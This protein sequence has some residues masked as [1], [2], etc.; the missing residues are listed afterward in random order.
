MATAIPLPHT[1]FG[2]LGFTWRSKRVPDGEAFPAMKAAIEHGATIWSSSSIY[3]NP[4][5]PPTAGL[6]LLRRYFT[7]YPED[8]SKVELFIRACF[9]APTF[10]AKCTRADVRASWEECNR[11]LGGVKS[12]DV[13]GPARID[14][15]VP[16]EET[17]CALKELVDEG[18]ISAVGLSEVSASTIRRAAAICPIK[19]AEIEF[20]L[21]SAE[22][23][24]NG[25]ALAAKETNLTILSYAP[26]G[27]G[28]LSGAI[29]TVEDIPPGDNRHM[30]GRFQPENFSKNLDLVNKIVAFAE[31][32]GVT[33]AQLALAWIRSYSNTGN[34]GTI[35]PI[36]GATK[37]YRVKENC[38]PV[39]LSAQ[40]REEL[41]QIVKS[42]TV[43]G[44]RQIPGA[45]HFL[46]T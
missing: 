14:P 35:I 10:T 24:D 37:A 30:F 5:D 32:K 46:W 38:T 39:E 19:Y 27:Y 29:K 33:P 11:I 13:F 28:F 6:E 45:D 26:L 31:K 42:F 18:K 16:V 25:V 8:A 4:P 20:S 12:I 17:V 9:D 43:V 15:N 34:C 44:H 3:G 41:G 2:L 22:M 21:W 40:E 23:L 1:A 7:R 36:P